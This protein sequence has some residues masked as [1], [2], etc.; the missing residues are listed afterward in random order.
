MIIRTVEIEKFRAFKN[1]SF[2]LGKRLTAISGRN[3]TQKTTLLGMIGQPFS[4]S[5]KNNPMYGCKTIDGYNFRSQF[6]EKF[7]ISPTHDIIG[8]HKWTLKLHSGV[9]TSPQFKVESIARRQAGRTPTLRFWNAES[10]SKGAGYIQLP[11]Y[12]LSL[13]RLFPIGESGKTQNYP[14]N[15]TQE[16]I[17]YCVSAYQTILCVQ[18]DG[19]PSSINLE[20]GSSSRVFSGISDNVHDIFTNSAGEGNIVR[21]ILAVLSFKRL[22]ETYPHDYKGGIL[23]ID[24]LDAT[25]YGFS[26][27]QLINYL[28]DAADKYKIQIVF[29]THSPIILQCVNKYQR[30][31][32]AEVGISRPPFAYDGAIV[33]LEPT[34]D[35]E[36]N[37][38]INTKNISTSNELNHILSDINLTLPSNNGKLNV[39][40]EDACAVSFLKYILSNSLRHIVLD[41]Y[42]NFIDIN[43][44]WPN[45]VQLAR[46]GVPEFLNNLI[47]LD[48]D[49]PQIHKSDEDNNTISSSGNFL[50]LPFVIERDI[51]SMLKKHQFFNEFSESVSSRPDFTY[52]ICFNKWPLAPSRYETVNFKEWFQYAENSLGSRNFLFS[53]W[54]QTHAEE[55]STF[56]ESFINTFNRLAERSNFD[57]IPHNSEPEDVPTDS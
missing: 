17:D 3:A 33:Y 44:G 5:N 29:T 22:K 45:Y 30:K 55:T 53:Y 43:L 25:L 20:K 4:I 14:T 56:I 15:L 18:D 38:T 52:D 8:E 41:S 24:E 1:T 36:G 32:R 40:C 23:L 50:F 16:E 19:S 57:S 21:I 42:I 47:V 10:R 6:S 37:R 28:W 46:K 31:E 12:F 34:Y 48:G 35:A 26:Q 11:V 7:K 13:S 9:H 49:V 27:M 39:Y 2:H 54:C 51:F